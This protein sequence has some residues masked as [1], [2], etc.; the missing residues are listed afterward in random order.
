MR[1]MRVQ[2]DTLNECHVMAQTRHV[3]VVEYYE[4]F[5]EA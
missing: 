3:S 5:L 4:S 2:M 1:V